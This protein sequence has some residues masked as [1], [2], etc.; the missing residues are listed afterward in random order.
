MTMESSLRQFLFATLILISLVGC[1]SREEKLQAAEETARLA[2]DTK[3][4]M[5]KG[6]G[7][8]LQ[9]EGKA[10]AEALT[11]GVGAVVKGVGKG[12]DASLQEVKVTVAQSLGAKGIQA[13][14]ASRKES[15]ISVY[16]V[17]EQ[18]FAG[19]LTLRALDSKQLEVGRATVKVNE[20]A[21]AANYFD[22]PF[23]SRTPM[24][25]VASFELH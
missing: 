15:T 1:K 6:I 19:T 9:T 10:G 8:S 7:E 16:V 4:R 24:A 12:F 22:F 13:T 20:T 11:Q 23:D 25:A 5:V 3:G 2:A 17:L 21:G 18:A 14:R